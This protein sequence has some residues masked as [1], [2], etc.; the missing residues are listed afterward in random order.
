M[1]LANTH[2]F[3]IKVAFEMAFDV[4]ILGLVINND[5]LISRILAIV[6]ESQLNIHSLSANHSHLNIT[7]SLLILAIVVMPLIIILLLKKR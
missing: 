7:P 1:Q 3:V 4:V 5:T 2:S 6:P